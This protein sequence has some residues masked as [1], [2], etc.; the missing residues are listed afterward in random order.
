MARIVLDDS[1][2]DISWS[3]C[4]SWLAAATTSGVVHLVAAETGAELTTW[5]AHDNG[6]LA[7]RWHPRL[8]LFASSG[9][10]GHVKLWQVSHKE[11]G[12]LLADITLSEDA[13]NNWIEHL[14]WRPDGAQ[15]AASCGKKII[16]LTPDG[17]VQQTYTFPGGTVGA[18]CWRP[19]GAQLAAAGYGGIR[20]YNVLDSRSKPQD[21]EWKGSLLSVKWSPDGRVI[22]AGCQDNTVHFWRMP[23][24]RDAMMSGFSYKPV[25]LS[26][27]N[28]NRW[29]LTGGSTEL[30]L[31]PFD[32]KGPEGRKPLSLPYHPEAICAI[33]IAGSGQ[34]LATGC[35]AGIVALWN[36]IGDVTPTRAVPL[37]SRVEQLSWSPHKNTRLLASTSRYGTLSLWDVSS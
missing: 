14:D 15:L 23:E 2:S 24:L 26:W 30:I 3:A 20:I 27:S 6:A 8:P 7:V 34:R 29:L 36:Q 25:Q 5:K 18:L 16:L 11:P 37:D 10:D 31:W 21:L 28:N 32:K 19:K 33:S 17:S 12:A 22:A 35:R 13:G 4:G 9:Q 1:P